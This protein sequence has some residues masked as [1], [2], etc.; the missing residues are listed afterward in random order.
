MSKRYDFGRLFFPESHEDSLSDVILFQPLGNH[1]SNVRFLVNKWQFPKVSKLSRKRISKS[2]GLHDIG[3]P[4]KF[5]I[6]VDFK[7][8]KPQLTYSFSGHRFLAECPNDPWVEKLARGH[9]D[10]SVHDI[11]RDTYILKNLIN[12]LDENNPLFKVA[13]SY[14]QDLS[15]DSLIYAQELYILE[16]C[17]QIEA[18]IACRFYEDDDQA[19]SRAFMDFNITSDSDNKNIFYIEPWIFEEDKIKLTLATWSMNIPQELKD[20][21]QNSSEEDKQKLTQDLQSSIK[22]WWKS[23]PKK[24]RAKTNKVILKPLLS[25]RL[26]K[27]NATQLY[28]K[29]KGFTPNPMQEKLINALN[30]EINPSPSCLLK[31][32]TGSGKLEAILIPSLAYDYKLILVLPTKSLLEDHRQR[33]DSYLLKFSELPSNQDRDISLVID[34]GTK[35]TR[36]IYKNGSMRL[37]ENTPRRHLYKGNIILT[38]LDKFMYRYFSFGDKQKSFIFPYRI[39]QDNTLICFDEA[40]S[41]D[42]ISFTNFCSLIKALYEAGR[43]LI[44]MT[45]TLSHKHLE[46]FDYLQDD[47][48]DYIDDADNLQKLYKFSQQI[49]KQQF[50][51]QKHFEWIQDVEHNSESPETFHNAFTQRV[52]NEWQSNSNQRI[53]ATV[54][55]VKDAVVIYEKIKSILETNKDSQGRFLFLYHGRIS[56]IPKDSEFSRTNIYQQIKARDEKNQPYILVTTSAIEVG[57]DLNST[58][59]I[60][61]FCNPENLIQRGGRCNR[62]GDIKGAKIIVIGKNIPEFANTLS[63]FELKNYQ[64]VLQNLN[65]KNFDTKTI[66]NCVSSKQQVDDYRVVELFSMLHDYVYNA[67]L[68]CQPSHEKGLVITRSWTP[69]VTLVYDNGK[70][71]DKMNEMPQITVPINRLVIQKK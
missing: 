38:T 25:E 54:E 31:A 53:I 11:C 49:L 43:S 57:C 32:P 4:Q 64:L 26:E 40:H 16:M 47:L 55:T 8:G 35:M 46:R 13:S 2:A 14:Y 22:N 48:I 71:R 45:A 59:L 6:K 70:N 28:Q 60:T 51:N 24:L 33:I 41:Y 56:D 10:Y 42:D 50:V 44:L 52:L 30:P 58:K 67:D 19:E 66:M 65:N 29:L 39:H 63:E 36:Y 61:Q 5:S 62:K 7:K 68:T 15:V 27:F 20:K 34:T 1:V 12:G 3:K 18:E 21:I 37:P 69:S 17:D 23:Q 9:H